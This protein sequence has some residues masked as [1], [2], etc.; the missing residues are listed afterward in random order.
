MIWFYTKKQVDARM[1][2]FEKD[3]EALNVYVEDL[4]R[5]DTGLEAKCERLKENVEFLKLELD[6]LKKGVKP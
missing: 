3:I 1:G 2:Y 6:T 5:E 4:E